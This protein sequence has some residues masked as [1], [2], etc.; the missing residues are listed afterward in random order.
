MAK[1]KT[2][3]E[4]FS[5]GDIVEVAQAPH[6]GDTDFQWLAGKVIKITTRLHVQHG[7]PGHMAYAR[8]DYNRGWIRKV[9]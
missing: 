2:Y 3:R 4:L 8:A 1:Q 5:V 6:D 9:R 7:G